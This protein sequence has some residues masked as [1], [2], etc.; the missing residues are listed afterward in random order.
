MKLLR[1]YAF[2]IL[3]VAGSVVQGQ[4]SA[5]GAA[6]SA[7]KEKLIG[8]WHLAHIESP[9]ADGD[10]HPAAQPLGMLIYTRDGHLS[11]QL[12][13]PKASNAQSNEYVLD[14]YEASFGSYDIDPATHTLTHHIQG[15]ITREMLVGKDLPRLY[16][17]TADGHLV[18]RSANPAEHWSVTWEHY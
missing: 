1:Y 8:A 15:S 10:T 16:Q 6:S 7:D 12:M 13:Y 18:I 5:T 9:G 11:V 4:S 2:G 3:I 14:G 17:F